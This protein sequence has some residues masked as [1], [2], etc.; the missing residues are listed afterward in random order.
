MNTAVE[1]RLKE[2]RCQKEKEIKKKLLLKE[3]VWKRI[4]PEKITDLLMITTSEKEFIN[5]EESPAIETASVNPV[6]SQKVIIEN[7]SCLS[8]KHSVTPIRGTTKHNEGKQL[9]S[10]V[11]TSWEILVFCVRMKIIYYIFLE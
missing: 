1:N 8:K 7:K 3:P 9:I 11:H 6:L 2:Y 10:T 5:S 4:L